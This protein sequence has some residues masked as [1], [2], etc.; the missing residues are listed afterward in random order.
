MAP[1]RGV[2]WIGI[3]PMFLACRAFRAGRVEKGLRIRVEKPRWV[4]NFPDE[5]KLPPWHRPVE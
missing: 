3:E 4:L 1:T 5:G 2:D